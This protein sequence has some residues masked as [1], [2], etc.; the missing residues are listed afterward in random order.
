MI[1]NSG[2]GSFQCLGLVMDG[3]AI[4]GIRVETH[5]FASTRRRTDSERVNVAEFSTA[6][7]ESSH[8]AVLD[9]VPGHDAIILQGHL[10][11]L[12]GGAELVTSYLYNG[13]TGEY[14]SCQIRLDRGPDSGWRLMDRHERIVS[15]IVVKT[16][17]IPL[18]GM[19]GI[20]TLEGACS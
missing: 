1:D 2:D 13:I 17:E 9:G 5:S 8:G 10:P 4:K 11:T 18:I 12:P 6:V 20:S 16:R 14:R 15:R 3:Q 7:L 19:F